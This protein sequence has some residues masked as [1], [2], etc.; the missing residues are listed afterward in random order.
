VFTLSR[1]SFYGMQL[2]EQLSVASALSRPAVVFFSLFLLI[3]TV[4]LWQ[5]NDDDDDDDDDDA[6]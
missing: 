6:D 1:L 4:I 2:L 5:I 3:V